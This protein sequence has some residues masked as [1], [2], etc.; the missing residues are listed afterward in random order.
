M[1][2][3]KCLLAQFLVLA[4]IIALLFW[5]RPLEEA[6][7]TSLTILLTVALI[8]FLRSKYPERYQKDERTIKASSYAASW[9]WLATLI[10]VSLLF[11]IDYLSI[12]KIEVSTAILMIFA[13]QI[14]SLL[15]F[16]WYFTWRGEL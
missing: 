2:V 11:W 9:S 13:T 4:G 15:A 1:K 7:S 16:R 12:A 8:L 3:D 14:L 6:I 10:V 5:K